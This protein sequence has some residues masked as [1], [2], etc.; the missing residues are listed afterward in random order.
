MLTACH[1]L[2]KAGKFWVFRKAEMLKAHN[3]RLNAPIAGKRK[4]IGMY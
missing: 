3:I 1:I 4:E 2:T